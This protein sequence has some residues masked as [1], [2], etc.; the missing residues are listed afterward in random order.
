MYPISYQNDTEAKKAI[1]INLIEVAKTRTHLTSERA[2]KALEDYTFYLS[3]L[4]S[5]ASERKHLETLLE[6]YT[7][8]HIYA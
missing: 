2:A 3:E 7:P 6:S 8:T 4:K 5:L 1:I